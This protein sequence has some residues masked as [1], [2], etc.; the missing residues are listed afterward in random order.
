M[1]R[2][3]EEADNTAGLSDDTVPG[4]TQT[5]TDTTSVD[6]A[7]ENLT[8]TTLYN[9]DSEMNEYLGSVVEPKAPKN[10]PKQ[11]NRK[12]KKAKRKNK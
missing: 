4:S 3:F 6:K 7:M 12:K 10:K 1:R 8:L 9:D 11:E 5:E 2:H